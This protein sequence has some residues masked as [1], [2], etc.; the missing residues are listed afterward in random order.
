MHSKRFTEKYAAIFRNDR[1]KLDRIVLTSVEV[2]QRVLQGRKS[3]ITGMLALCRL[4]E[5]H[6]IAEQYKIFSTAGHRHNICQWNLP[7]FVNKKIIKVVTPISMREEP[8]CSGYN[9]VLVCRKAFSVICCVR[10]AW[11]FAEHGVIAAAAGFDA[12]ERKAL[13]FQY[14]RTCLDQIHDRLVAIGSDA[15]LFS[16]SKQ[17]G[18]DM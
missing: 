4:F 3:G 1:M 16:A 10:K 14:A 13:L 9:S 6:L 2:F 7:G 5:L 17:V 8:R 18:D 12:D 15:D 11:I